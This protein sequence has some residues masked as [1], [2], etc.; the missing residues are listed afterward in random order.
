MEP[1]GVPVSRYE[2]RLCGKGTV[3]KKRF[4]DEGYE[5]VR[6]V[7]SSVLLQLEIVALYAEKYLH[8]L[9]LGNKDT[10]L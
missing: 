2:G 8:E 7:Y 1:I 10:R 3:G 9:L 5:L 4:N 6:K